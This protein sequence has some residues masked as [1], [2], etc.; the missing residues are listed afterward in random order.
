MWNQNWGSMLWGGAPQPVPLLG[1]LGLVLVAMLLMVLGGILLRSPAAGRR[2]GKATVLL[3]LLVPL[4]AFAVPFTFSNGTVADANQV[5]QN[6]ASLEARIVALEAKR[7][8][9]FAHVN[10]NGTIDSH[11]GNITVE[12]AG[13]GTYCAA[14]SGA[15]PKGAVATLDSRF[16]VGG[17]VQTGVF[18]ASVCPSSAQQI[19]IM[20]RPHAQ[21]GGSPGQDRAFYLLVN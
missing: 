1:L 21:D 8:L 7:V 13:A 11:S 10:A 4:S 3:V 5:N 18:A 2:M 6:F 9:A 15:T 19:L 12:K 14:V 17:S 20:T 16:N